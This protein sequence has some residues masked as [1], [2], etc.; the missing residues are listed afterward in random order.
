MSC[1][2]NV[3]LKFAGCFLLL[4][5]LKW[6]F[7]FFLS[8][9]LDFFKILHEAH[10]FLRMFDANKNEEKKNLP[11]FSLENFSGKKCVGEVL[12]NSNE[13]TLSFIMLKDAPNILKRP[14]GIHIVFKV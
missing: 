13:L 6:L 5:T 9:I 4:F 12:K 2:L 7:G 14:C 10:T 8:F 11:E 1:L 3:I